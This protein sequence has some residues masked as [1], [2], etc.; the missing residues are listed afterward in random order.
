LKTILCYGDSNTWGAEPITDLIHVKRF[1]RETR[2]GGVLARE[3]GEDFHVIV[4][5]NPGRTT[6]W[7]DPISGDKNGKD[8]LPQCLDSHQ[9]LDL[10]IILL[11]TNDLKY[12]FSLTAFDIARAA[13]VLVGEVQKWTPLVGETPGV[14]LISPPPLKPVPDFLAQMFLGAEEKSVQFSIEFNQVSQDFGCYFLDAGKV[15]ESSALDGIHFVAADHN[16]LGKAIAARILDI[17]T[18]D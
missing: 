13:G 1:P 9:P 18:N 10:V 2:W 6:L 4:E 7:D 17:F 5:G 12:R 3:L 15:M 11:G 8:Y 14:M 16:K